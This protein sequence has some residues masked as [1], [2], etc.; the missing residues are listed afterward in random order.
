[1]R[2]AIKDEALAAEAE[3]V[4]DADRDPAESRRAIREAVER[5]YTAPGSAAGADLR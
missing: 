2:E 5:R 1:M 4:E 3:E